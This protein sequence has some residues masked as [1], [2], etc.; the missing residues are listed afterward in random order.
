[1]TCPLASL[2]IHA[3]MLKADTDLDKRDIDWA[4]DRMADEK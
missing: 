4:K 1:M 3:G 2:R